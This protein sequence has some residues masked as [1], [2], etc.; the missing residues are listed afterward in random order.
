M[1]Q[2]D[3]ALC[4]VLVAVTA[5][6]G[7]LRTGWGGDEQGRTP[8]V[9]GGASCR[10]SWTARRAPRLKPLSPRGRRPSLRGHPVLKSRPMRAAARR[11]AP[12]VAQA[13]EPPSAPDLP[14]PLRPPPTEVPVR[15]R[16]LRGTATCSRRLGNASRAPR[17][18]RQP[19]ASSSGA[20]LASVTDLNAPSLLQLPRAAQAAVL[21]PRTDSLLPDSLCP[22]PVCP[23]P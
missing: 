13:R 20:F 17:P 8:G 11:G 3:P 6:R 18:R 23:Q 14:P 12:S 7:P 22:S 5:R 15:A 19:G 21:P 9:G 4:R 10:S 16:C 1:W 2:D